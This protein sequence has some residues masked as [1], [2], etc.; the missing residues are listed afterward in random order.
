MAWAA[1]GVGVVKTGVSLWQGAK[2]R[3]AAA[4]AAAEAKAEQQ[5]QQRL[6]DIQKQEYK[7]IEYK[8]PY[9]NME[10]VYEDLTV[11]TQQAEFQAQQ[12]DQ[13][14][15]NIMQNLSS[16]AGGSGIAALAQSMANQGQLQTQQISASIGQQEAANQK[17]MAQGAAGVQEAKLAGEQWVQ[18][19]DIGRTETLLGMQMGAASGANTAAQ[20]AKAMQMETDMA[21]RE[22]TGKAVGEL[23]GAVVSNLDS[24]GNLGK[25]GYDWKG[26]AI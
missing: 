7:N 25:E 14:R 6:L 2:N 12:G 16:A 11:N 24:L 9:E 23:G 13:Q 15:A 3:K 5:K 21:A 18:Q 17:L 22:A 8:N 4:K 1:I 20:Q 26:Q 19:Q 10:N